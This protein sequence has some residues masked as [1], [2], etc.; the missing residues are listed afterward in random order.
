[1][2]QLKKSVTTD[3]ALKQQIKDTDGV[4]DPTLF[5]PKEARPKKI[6]SF[7]LDESE[8]IEKVTQ[9]PKLKK[10]QLRIY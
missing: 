2:Y 10:L 5:Q 9:K 3:D 4:L 1:M 6:S 7:V 8:A